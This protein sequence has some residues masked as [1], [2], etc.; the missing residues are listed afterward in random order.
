MWAA[1]LHLAAMCRRPLA[2]AQ[3]F[4]GHHALHPVL[5]SAQGSCSAWWSWLTWYYS[6][7][8]IYYSP[9]QRTSPGAGID[10]QV[11]ARLVPLLLGS[12]SRSRS[13]MAQRLVGSWHP[14]RRLCGGLGSASRGGSSRRMVPGVRVGR[15]R[16]QQ[17]D[18]SLR[19]CVGWLGCIVIFVLGVV[20][21]CS[22]NPSL[23]P[24]WLCEIFGDVFLVVR[25]G[26]GHPAAWIQRLVRAWAAS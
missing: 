8:P 14:T 3:L 1:N 22:M 25:V 18:R 17:S 15:G 12:A 16:H 23:P 10:A 2:N 5:G 19:A 11:G 21:G 20:V 24:G 6:L 7:E 4:G 13:G 9:V 26:S